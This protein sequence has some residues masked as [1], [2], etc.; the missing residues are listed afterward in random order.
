[1][2]TEVRYAAATDWP[3]TSPTLEGS[4][5]RLEPL[6]LDHVPGLVEI[7]LVPEIWQWTT[8]RITN[9]A[10][11]RGYVEAALA[12]QARGVSLPFATVLRESGKVVGSTRFG[13]VTP[14]HRRVEIGW[15]WV[16]PPWQRSAVNTEA[17]LLMLRYA[18]EALGCIRVE[19][20]THHENFKSQ[21]AMQ[22]LGAV[23]EGVFRN[24]MIQ[25]DGTLRHS[26]YFRIA[27]EQ[28]PEV[29][30]N[31]EAKLAAR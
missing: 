25:S 5:V 17:K 31:L 22:R 9:D 2:N 1:M 12:E 8:V 7:G 29:K 23:R 24:H 14:E 28:W 16:A 10:E 27:V 3:K 18:F 30:A 15:T 20:K 6:S 13:N 21:N 19:L 11:M 26:V 4:T